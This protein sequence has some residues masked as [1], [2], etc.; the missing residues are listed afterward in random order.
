MTSP[1]LQHDLAGVE[2]LAGGVGRAHARAAAAHRARVG[3]EQLLPGEVLDDAG[4]EGLE[5]RLG[6]VRHRLHGA[7]RPVLVPQVHVEGRREHV[8][9]HGDGQ[10][11]R[12]RRRR[13][14]RGR[15]TW[16]GASRRACSARRRR[17]GWPAGSRRSSTAR[18]SGDPHAAMR[19]ISVAKP[20]SPISQE[21][22][23]DHGVLGLGLDAD[24]VR[25]LDVAAADG[26]GDAGQEHEAGGVA[27]EGVAPGT[28]CRAGTSGS[29][30]AG[31]RSRGSW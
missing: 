4:P 31:G 14:A 16:P 6:Q 23:E 21:H 10:D 22:A 3:V 9:Q 2:R 17:R 24:A 13:P 19:N 12:G 27:D 30:G 26:P 28:S 8:P 29:R 5:R 7:L 1:D 15:S 25:A 20:V 18:T 11:Q